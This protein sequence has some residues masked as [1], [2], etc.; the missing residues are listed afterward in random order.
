MH[1][2][3]KVRA[4]AVADRS[5]IRKSVRRL[6]SRRWASIR[7]FAPK[8]FIWDPASNSLRCPADKQL[9]YAGQSRK[10]GNLYR[11]YR[12]QAA[13]CAACPC[14]PRCCPQ[15]S[16]GRTVSIVE[17]ANAAVAEMRRRMN[18]EQAKQIYRQRGAVAE[19]PNA[20][21]AVSPLT[22]RPG[23]SGFIATGRTSFIARAGQSRL[24]RR[25][26]MLTAM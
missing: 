19:F 25:L 10:E 12:A 13:D 5:S 15:T 2:G 14:R 26:V 3:T 16:N 11:R 9:N 22:H 1:D 20:C 23:R 7:R 18:T 24:K 8:F 6:Q 21:A 4:Q 17:T